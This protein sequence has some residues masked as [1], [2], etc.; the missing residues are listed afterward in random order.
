[1]GRVKPPSLASAL[2]TPV[3][4]RVLGLLYGQP[5]RRFQTGELLR[6]AKS[7]TGAVHRQLGRLAAT[8]LVTVTSIGNQKLYQA[9]HASPVFREL[10]GLVTKTVGVAEPLRR[11]L[12]P[13]RDRIV[14]A[15]VYGSVA[16]ERDRADSD[17]DLLV[18]SDSVRHEELYAALA[19][20]ERE[21]DRS[22]DLRLMTP[23]AWRSKRAVDDSFVARVAQLP[24]WMVI[25]TDDDLA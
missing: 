12:G 5:E 20:A 10:H 18:L 22:I 2:F 9:N 17:I 4:Q 14:A 16:Q 21:L 8:G 15:F 13:L 7:G 11:A 6:L 25:G 1:M 19:D 23:D 3:Q 24:R